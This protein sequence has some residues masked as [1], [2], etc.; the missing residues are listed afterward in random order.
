MEVETSRI[1]QQPI[2]KLPAP[3]DVSGQQK[4]S[5]LPFCLCFS[6]F[7]VHFGQMELRNNTGNR[8]LEAAVL[9]R[10][11][12]T[13]EQFITGY[14]ST[15]GKTSFGMCA[16]EKEFRPLNGLSTQDEA[17]LEASSTA[18]I[19]QPSLTYILREANKWTSALDLLAEPA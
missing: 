19:G 8:I 15:Q 5:E 6:D 4:P 16:P 3:S 17:D 12:L 1:Y 14:K 18:L 7:E 10:D 9:R 13:R 2:P 11:K